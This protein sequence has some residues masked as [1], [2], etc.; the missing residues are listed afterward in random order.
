MVASGSLGSAERPV[1]DSERISTVRWSKDAGCETF[2]IEFTNDAGVPAVTPP[3][4]T[5]TLIREIG[6]IRVEL[7]VAETGLSDQLVETT[8]VDRLFV[9]RQNDGNLFVDLLLQEP[10]M[11][12]MI[13]ATSPARIE[14]EMEPGGS[15][16]DGRPAIEPNVVLT[17]PIPGEHTYP[18]VV[19]GYARTFEANVVARL[20]RD[21][22]RVAEAFTTAADWLETWGEFEMEIADG[23]SGDLSLFVGEASAESGAPLGVTVAVTLE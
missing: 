16:F 15:F 14:I 10:A 20:N 8:L 21:G 23:P 17:K 5:A 1:A 2:L 11:A 9:V 7:N 18:L 13:T 6:V 4:V 3:S 22:E 12:R 19:S